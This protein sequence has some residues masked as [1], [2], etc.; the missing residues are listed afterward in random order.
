MGVRGGWV[1]GSGLHGERLADAGPGG[2]FDGRE[3]PVVMHGHLEA[4]LRRPA[5]GDGPGDLAVQGRYVRG[6]AGRHPGRDET[7]ADRDRQ[8][9]RGSVGAPEPDAPFGPAGVVPR[10][11]RRDGQRAVGARDDDDEPAGRGRAAA[12]D[13][14][15]EQRAAAQPAVQRDLAGHV[16]GDQFAGLHHRDPVMQVRQDGGP[17][18]RAG[19]HDPHPYP[20]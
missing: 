20:F 1:A 15:R 5:Q 2:P 19:A 6:R 11:G 10:V 8:V 18:L 12:M 9:R 13:A 4:G 17:A 3:R 14:Q 16:V 7:V